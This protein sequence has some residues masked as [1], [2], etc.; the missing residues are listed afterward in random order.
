MLDD[1]NVL[2]QRDP[3]RVFESVCH[4]TELLAEAIEVG[5]PEHDG[6]SIHTVVIVGRNHELLAADLLYAVIGAATPIVRHSSSE[7][8]S[9]A[10]QNTLVI[11][12]GRDDYRTLYQAARM[13][14]CQ[15]AV[16]APLSS[17]LLETVKADGVV[18]VVR[19]NQSPR[20]LEIT[21][22]LMALATLLVHFGCTDNKLVQDMRE[23]SN[24]LKEH[25]DR[26]HWSVPVHENYAKQ[27]SLLAV[28]KTPIFCSTSPTD[29]LARLWKS[30]WNE[31]A[32]NTAFNSSYSADGQWELAG[33]LSHPIEKP[34]GIFDFISDLDEES[35][36]TSQAVN[37]VLSGKRPTSN[38]IHLEGSLHIRQLL[39]GIMLGEIT[40]FY[41]AILNNVRPDEVDIHTKLQNA[42]EIN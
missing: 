31:T 36:T 29:A 22:L 14:Q 38:L 17:A 15:I 33:W 2:K 27:L 25:I 5:A 35:M 19:Q 7:L 24:W 8:P 13:R 10:D 9:Y 3:H 26:W 1:R 32:K 30:A 37:R 28:G 6:R 40:A 42:K 34:F 39:F 21:W 18:Y 41:V 4:T 11:I 20:R 16:L 12:A 23:S